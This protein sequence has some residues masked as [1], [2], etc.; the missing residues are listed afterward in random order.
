MKEYQANYTLLALGLGAAFFLVGDKIASMLKP[1]Q[2]KQKIVE[3][4]PLTVE[5]KVNKDN[6]AL[7][8]K[9]ETLVNPRV[10]SLPS[11]YEPDNLKEDL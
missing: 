3:K 2:K 7:P 1:A 8:D 10:T 9:T 11:N 5:E 4:V 6:E